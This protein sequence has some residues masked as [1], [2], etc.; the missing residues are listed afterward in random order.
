LKNPFGEKVGDPSLRSGAVLSE[1]E[2]MT[3][4]PEKRALSAISSQ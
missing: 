2:G 3:K 1:I 4:S